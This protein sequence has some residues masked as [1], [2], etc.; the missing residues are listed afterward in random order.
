MAD[1][2]E[3]ASRLTALVTNVAGRGV[4]WAS[5][6]ALVVFVAAVI[7][8]L[9]GL[10]ALD[11]PVGRIW[12]VLGAVIG[13]AAVA[14]PLLARWRLGAVT[15][16]ASAIVGEVRTLV[17]GDGTARRVVIDTVEASQPAMT[18]QGSMIV[19]R[20]DGASFRDLR[21]VVSTTANLRDLPGALVAVTTFPGL[22][23][24]GVAATLVFG[25]ISLIFLIALAF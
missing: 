7:M 15:K 19:V 18:G 9:L 2:D 25:F 21:R 8:Y 10:Q 17:A 4:R 1:V 20:S 16:R 14:A 22:L 12:P 24:I 23:A 3:L 5:R 11:G 13:L 6:V